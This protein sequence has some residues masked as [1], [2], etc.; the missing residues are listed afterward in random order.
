MILE[1]G[2]IALNSLNPD[3][4]VAYELEWQ[5]IITPLKMVDDKPLFPLIRNILKALKEKDKL[6]LA[7]DS[8][9]IRE[10]NNIVLKVDKEKENLAAETNLEHLQTDVDSDI[11]KFLESQ[12]VFGNQH[13]SHASQKAETKKPDE[14]MNNLQFENKLNNDAAKYLKDLKDKEANEL[15]NLVNS[16]TADK[17]D[18][19]E[20]MKKELQE[21]LKSA[22]TPEEKQKLLEEYAVK[23]LDLAAEIDERKNKDAN[24]LIDNLLD[25]HKNKKL[26]FYEDQKNQVL[27]S[28]SSDKDALIQTLDRKIADL[29][30]PETRKT[31]RTELEKLKDQQNAIAESLYEKD[32]GETLEEMKARFARELAEKMKF[33]QAAKLVDENSNLES[34]LMGEVEEYVKERKLVSK[35]LRG[36]RRVRKDTGGSE[37]SGEEEVELDDTEKMVYNLV[38]SALD[39]NQTLT[40]NSKLR[41]ILTLES[42]IDKK[43]WPKR[44][45]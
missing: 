10:A 4:F 43:N 19:L 36:R 44:Q 26:A 7:P 12:Q 27:N 42:K 13:E 32:S 31:L 22:S 16:Y 28:N 14:K 2:E 8:L 5:N 33:L 15:M 1:T 17:Y 6:L 35:K 38:L 45:V 9:A 29:E 20:K 41:V 40:E 25:N 39:D 34:N 11:N 3:H 30:E 18:T 37:E 21:K 24:Q 23:M